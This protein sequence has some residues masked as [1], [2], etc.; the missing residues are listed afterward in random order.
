VRVYVAGQRRSSG[1]TKVGSY[2][3]DHTKTALG[4]LLNTGSA[5]GAFANLL[6]SGTPLTPVV[7]SFCQV[8]RGQLQ[9]VWDLRKLFTTAAT[10]MRRR[11]QLLTELH[12]D[13]YYTLYERT[14]EA[15]RKAI[16]E[17]EIRRLR[18]SV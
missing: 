2:L 4:S 13:L 11:G 1:R 15:R 10:V 18:R 6:P 5:I 14:A 9:E 17:G 7:P 3:G 16:R 8:N 12:K